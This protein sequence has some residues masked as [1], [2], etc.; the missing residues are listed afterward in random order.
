M[1]REFEIF[2][3]PLPYLQMEAD[4]GAINFPEAEHNNQDTE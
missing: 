1:A 4:I 3:N 2:K